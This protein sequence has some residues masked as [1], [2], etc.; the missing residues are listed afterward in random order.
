MPS[1]SSPANQLRPCLAELL[2]T[3][4]YS[5]C[6]TFR[7]EKIIEETRRID[8]D[9]EGTRQ[10]MT[11]RNLVGFRLVLSDG[12]LMINAT[13][14]NILHQLMKNGSVEEGAFIEITKYGLRK[15]KRLNGKGGLLYMAIE[16]FHKVSD[17]GFYDMNATTR[18]DVSS[19][20]HESSTDA[21]EASVEVE[22]L[23]TQVE[24]VLFR[25]SD[26]GKALLPE[27]SQRE[28]PTTKKSLVSASERNSKRRK[29]EISPLDDSN[30]IL[31]GECY[32]PLSMAAAGNIQE[33]I[34]NNPNDSDGFETMNRDSALIH[35]RREVLS[36]LS[37]N[38]RS[39]AT[40]GGSL[41]P[42]ISTNTLS[43][44]KFPRAKSFQNF[45]VESHDSPI[46]YKDPLPKGN[47]HLGLAEQETMIPSAP[48]HTLLS[49]LEPAPP[50]PQKTYR[51]A[52]FGLI[53]W[54]SPSI[55]RKLGF[56]PKRHIKIHDQSVGDRYSGISISIFHNAHNFVP[57]VGT[58]VLFSG[59]TAQWWEKE[60][61]LNAY[62]R[63]C[64]DHDWVLWDEDLLQSKGFD[65][66]GL[67]SWWE[68]R[69]RR[70]AGK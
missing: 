2:R 14:K 39:S 1:S 13:V 45:K 52:I 46:R 42:T 56:P 17:Q 50:L 5:P 69:K 70:R 62:E 60:V 21:S 55:L 41:K 18:S 58:I 40:D 4:Y 9:C 32:G 10:L 63:D 30:K 49:L 15:A 26:I 25:P 7:I 24:E 35:K 20:R 12:E 65:V 44:L 66:Q 22:D 31:Q 54:V 27:A 51:C 23:P 3:R 59:L 48:V 57:E 47:L 34:E 68:E 67:R 29:T 38:T 43:N 16:G 19:I 64:Q 36:Q 53:S 8:A 11:P 33:T 37:G 6:L 28:I 61:I